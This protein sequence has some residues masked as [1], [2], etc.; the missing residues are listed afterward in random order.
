M[1]P[2]LLMLHKNLLL[3]NL[4]LL[5]WFIFH[6]VGWRTYLRGID[7]QLSPDFALAQ[8]R[9]QHW[10]H[11]ALRHLLLINLIIQPVFI[12]MLLALLLLLLGKPLDIVV[13]GTIFS[14]M[15][16]LVGGIIAAA[17]ISPAFSMVATAV[18]SL[19]IG[20]TFGIA[21][22][23]GA[24]SYAARNLISVAVGI[25]ALSMAGNSLIK[26]TEVDKPL[27]IGWQ[28]GSIVIALASSLLVLSLGFISGGRVVNAIDLSLN[29]SLDDYIAHGYLV[30]M[31]LAAGIYLGWYLKAWYWRF[32]LILVF[33]LIAMCSTVL[34]F[35]ILENW[36]GNLMLYQTLAGLA[37][38]TNNAMLFII[39][40][41]MPYLM[42][43]QFAGI[44]AGVIAGMLGGVGAYIVFLFSD[45]NE[46]IRWYALSIVVSCFLLGV[47]IHW[48]RPIMLYPFVAGWSLTL[49][50]RHEQHPE[51]GKALLQQHPAFWDDHQ[52]L[53]LPG[54]DNQLIL[55]YERD[56]Q[57]AQTVMTAL[58]FT[59]QS[60]AVHAAQLE[61]DIRALQR[62]QNIQTIADAHQQLLSGHD[63][64]DEI[65]R[66]IRHFRKSSYD[67]AARLGLKSAYQK[68]VALKALANHL[69][70]L[71]VG[72]AGNRN[73]QVQRLSPVAEKWEFLINRYVE[74]LQQVQEIDN[75][76][77]FGTALADKHIL[78]KGRTRVSKRIE[79]LLLDDGSP[80]LLLYGQ[81]RTGKTS[82]L[83]NLVSRL[84]SHF[85]LLF[86]D[87][88]GP[89][90]T[91]PNY[92]RFFSNLIWEIR[93][94]AEHRYPDLELPP[95]DE[96]RLLDDPFAG[97]DHWLNQLEQATA[98]AYLLLAFDEFE[99][100][101]EMFKQAQLDHKPILSTFRHIIQHR[102]RFRVL[103]CGAHTFKDDSLQH[104]AGYL[105]NVK[106]VSI[107]QFLDEA[108]ARELIE[109][110]TPDFPLIYSE[111]TCQEVLKLTNCH[112]ALLQL[113]CEEIVEVKNEQPPESRLNVQL[114]DIATAIPAALEQG[115][116]FFVD[117]RTK[118]LTLTARQVLEFIA[119]QPARL[120]SY[121]Q[122]ETVFSSISEVELQA[123]LQLA[124]K[125][126][127]IYQD[128]SSNYG[129]LVELIRRTFL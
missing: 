3:A 27:G 126:E 87:C 4:Q 52:R 35:N 47:T 55:L 103:F 13:L 41:A 24:D 67:V 97:F 88:Q 99:V 119:A 69:N 98:P 110:P 30:G 65:S 86:V 22:D 115:E 8:L 104:W 100:L 124:L 105:I 11:P 73:R 44:W 16:S 60:W 120:V 80:P 31:M 91:A 56:P 112:P 62:C 81:R 12:A 17:I 63:V 6:P 40:F 46:S 122:L 70:G 2:N 15:L 93:T 117:I 48:W 125:R 32:G 37:G 28:V 116:A 21:S 14:F 95:L 23:L 90:S 78:F 66:Y 77:K 75:P 1:T 20:L 72:I 18:G 76:Y 109:Q 5:F 38:G 43:R 61:L 84:P 128:D 129:F 64:N 33:G 57:A 96:A 79:R 51:L 42:T 82:L 94:Q 54:L 25:L 9:N 68:R 113:L 123:A 36:R 45:Q 118:Q 74:Q 83:N 121:V 50:H 7:P 111:T 59:N 10:H 39:L 101:E 114:E 71:A 34:V 26:L 127:L 58:S 89:V 102:P 106:K 19:P 107:G 53:Q 49:Y 85:L 108:D 29:L 92:A